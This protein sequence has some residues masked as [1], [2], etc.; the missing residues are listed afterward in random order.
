MVESYSGGCFPQREQVSKSGDRIGRASGWER[1]QRREIDGVLVWPPMSGHWIH[2]RQCR[3]CAVG[4]DAEGKM[5][6]VAFQS[7]TPIALLN[8][9]QRIACLHPIHVSS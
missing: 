1:V 4:L 6:I 9:L 7:R 5:P 2:W 8:Y 3:T